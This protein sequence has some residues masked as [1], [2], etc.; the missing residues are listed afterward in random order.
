VVYLVLYSGRLIQG[1][2]LRGT[3]AASHRSELAGV[4]DGMHSPGRW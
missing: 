4:E 3:E 2:G 1:Y